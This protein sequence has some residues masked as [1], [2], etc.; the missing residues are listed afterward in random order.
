VRIE[1]KEIQDDFGP[2][3]SMITNTTMM[4]TNTTLMITNTT[5]MV[6]KVTMVRA[7]SQSRDQPQMI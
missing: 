5:L 3:V 2:A 1:L 6:T 7:T 4:I